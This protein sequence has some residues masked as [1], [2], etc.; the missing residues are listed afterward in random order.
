M[1]TCT[2]GE[3]DNQ[4]SQSNNAVRS[5]TRIVE[6]TCFEPEFPCERYSIVRFF[7]DPNALG[8]PGE[9]LYVKFGTLI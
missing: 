5:K 3:S 6:C 2:N 4:L 9:S 7:L 8:E 1:A